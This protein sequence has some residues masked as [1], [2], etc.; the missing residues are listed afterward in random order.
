DTGSK[1][2]WAAS[3]LFNPVQTGM[4]YAATHI[5]VSTPL[6]ILQQNLF[7]WFYTAYVHRLG[8][9]LI[10]LNTG[11]LPGGASRYR[12]LV[13]QPRAEG[14]SGSGGR[15]RRGRP[16]RWRSRRPAPSPPPCPARQTRSSRCAR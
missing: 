4:R 12:E 11:R 2:W 5:G 14:G 13:A 3:A 15:R 6:K 1:L 9:Y 8:N 10:D 16:A 7:V